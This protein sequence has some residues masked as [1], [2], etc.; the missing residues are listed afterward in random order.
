MTASKPYVVQSTSRRAEVWSAYQIQFD[1]MRRHDWQGDLV[2]AL[3][4]ALFDLPPRSDHA[5]T[6]TYST[7][8]PGRCDAE[9][10]LFTNPGAATFPEGTLAIRWERGSEP[11]PPPSPVAD[12]AAGVHYYGY[13]AEPDFQ[14]WEPD[15]E[16]ASWSGVPRRLPDDGSARPMWLALREAVV[17]GR[18][19]LPSG[20]VADGTRFGLS[21]TVRAPLR[22]PRSAPALSEA[23]V[24]GVLCALHA[25]APAT[26]QGRVAELLAAKIP[27]VSQERLSDLV[28]ERPALF[29]GS[30]FLLSG[31]R[32]QLS[33]CDEFCDAGEIVIQPDPTVS[34]LQVSGR[35]YTLKAREA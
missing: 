30:P 10:R 2:R 17:D 7:S 1:G 24:D 25:G 29:A 22:G 21:L 34:T 5:L 15:Q 6:G 11:P 14:V 26:D 31:S 8:V 35:V 19:A 3:K 12:L 23:L 27:S 18:L 28:V 33:P 13:A 16:L 9:N 4:V 20:P 32:V